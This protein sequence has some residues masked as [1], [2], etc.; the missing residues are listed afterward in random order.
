[1]SA[2]QREQNRPGRLSDPW[3]TVATS[4][5]RE[6]PSG[7]AVGERSCSAASEAPRSSHRRSSSRRSFVPDRRLANN[8]DWPDDGIRGR[9]PPAGHDGG[10]D[11]L[12]EHPASS[13]SWPVSRH[14]LPLSEAAVTTDAS[15]QALSRD[16]LFDL[17]ALARCMRSSCS[18]RS[19]WSR[20]RQPLPPVRWPRRRSSSSSRTSATSRR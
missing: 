6:S 5:P 20:A 18:P 15:G 10:A 1:M 16:G 13:S 7:S 3:W 12:P 8:G 19:H 14:G 4:P 2:G 11:V 9:P 17:R